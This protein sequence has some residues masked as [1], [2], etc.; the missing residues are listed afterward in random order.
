MPRK[1]F[2]V[3]ANQVIELSEPVKLKSILL[4]AGSGADGRAI[5]KAGAVL[6]VAT[7]GSAIPGGGNTGDGTVDTISGSD[8][9]T[10]TE[11]W[12]LTCIVEA[13]DGGVFS[14]VGSVSG[15]KGNATVGSQYFS[16]SADH[17]KSEIS[18][19]I[20]DGA[21]DF[22]LGDTFTIAVV[23]AAYTEEITIAA[24]QKTSYA[25]PGF[26]HPSSQVPLVAPVTITITGTGAK[27]RV[28]Y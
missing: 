18:F 22:A 8:I 20:H 17:S 24:V 12:T 9:Y 3:G 4:A 1:L 25:W 26:N 6:S 2:D 7:F 14:V 23:S 19:L 15:A 16:N 11:T 28:D 27:V 21:T 10:L 5:M 13:V